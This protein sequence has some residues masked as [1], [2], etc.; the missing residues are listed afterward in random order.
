M[1]KNKKEDILQLGKYF[2]NVSKEEYSIACTY[3]AVGPVVL[4]PL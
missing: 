3:H 4:A 2:V 1:K